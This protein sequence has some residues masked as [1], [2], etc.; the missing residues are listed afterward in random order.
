[1]QKI[2][3]VPFLAH[4]SPFWVKK[5]FSTKHEKLSS[6]FGTLCIKRQSSE[7]EDVKSHPRK[8]VGTIYIEGTEV[9]EVPEE[10]DLGVITSEDLKQKKQVA[11]VVKSANRLRNI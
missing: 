5:Y 4:L 3:W 1:M 8:C 9:K 10:K 7:W 2:L 11:K 6:F